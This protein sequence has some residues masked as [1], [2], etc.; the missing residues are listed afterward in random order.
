[1]SC[2]TYTGAP[3]NQLAVISTY[4]PDGFLCIYH[5][6]R[7]LAV[8]QPFPGAEANLDRALKRAFDRWRAERHNEVTP[9][10]ASALS[11][12]ATFKKDFVII[13]AILTLR[14]R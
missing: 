3:S 7:S 9:E 13:L 1:M 4:I 12:D 5:Y 10:E 11:P 8:P 14:A 6:Y 2:L